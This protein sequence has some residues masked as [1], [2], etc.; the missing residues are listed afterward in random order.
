M[1]NFDSFDMTIPDDTM[2]ALINSPD[3]FITYLKLNGIRL[4]NRMVRIYVRTEAQKISVY[5]LGR[6]SKKDPRP[7]IFIF[8]EVYYHLG[9]EIDE[10]SPFRNR[11]FS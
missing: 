11:S 4:K 7:D 5:W 3:A 6:V 1:S 2:R 8:G 10:E 9:I